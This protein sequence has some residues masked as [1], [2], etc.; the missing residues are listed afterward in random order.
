VELRAAT[1]LAR[2]YRNQWKDAEARGLLEPV[3]GSF[4]ESQDTKELR[5]AR[6]PLEQLTSAPL[7]PSA[8]PTAP[9]VLE[10]NAG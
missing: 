10:N 4:R 6:A 5:R 7:L 2:L 3:C 1:S 9:T 8:Q